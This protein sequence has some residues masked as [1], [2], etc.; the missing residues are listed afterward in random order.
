MA[1]AA[2]WASA[3]AGAADTIAV[4]HE[5]PP[6]LGRMAVERQDAAVELPG[7][8]LFDPSHKSFATLLFPYLR[9][10][11]NE[12]SDG[13]SGKEEIRRIPGFDP[14]EH[15]LPGSWPGGLA[16]NIG[17]ENGVGPRGPLHVSIVL[18]ETLDRPVRSAAK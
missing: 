5:A 17:I 8:V 6:D 11:P 14:V 1:T 15:R 13:L 16:G 12:L 4:S 2:I 18:G 9:S 7:K 10:A 3:A